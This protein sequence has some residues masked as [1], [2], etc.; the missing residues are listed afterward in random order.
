MS[1]CGTLKLGPFTNLLKWKLEITLV[2]SHGSLKAIISP[3]ALLL[4]RLH[5]KLRLI[6]IVFIFKGTTQ[7]WDCSSQKR[8]R[9]MQGHS[10]RVCSLA[11]NQYILSSGSRSG[12]IIHH[13][14]RQRDHHVATLNGHSEEVCGL[15]W[16]PDGRY[17]ASGGNDNLLNIWASPQGALTTDSTPLHQLTAHQSAIKALAWCPWQSGIL[18][19]GGGTAD[20]CIKIW[21][22]NTGACVNSTDTKSQV[23]HFHGGLN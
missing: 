16:A 23:R 7:I 4:V 6:A 17:L 20:R 15:K 21:N 14:V 5:L 8:L 3:L 1:F 18:A 13:D 19:S 2:P 10:A 22:A 11:W 9:T 12:Q